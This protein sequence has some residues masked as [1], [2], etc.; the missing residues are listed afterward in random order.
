MQ[1]ISLITILI[2]LSNVYISFKGL[3]TTRFEKYKFNIYD[4]KNTID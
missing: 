3:K 1:S 4:L 2:I